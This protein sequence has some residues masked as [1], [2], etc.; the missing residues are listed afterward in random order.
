MRGDG[1]GVGDISEVPGDAWGSG[2]TTDCHFRFL[3]WP[4]YSLGFCFYIP[5]ACSHMS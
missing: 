3:F 1:M 5:P 4:S 2:H